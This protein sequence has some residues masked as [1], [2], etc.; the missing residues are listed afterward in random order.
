MDWVF[1][2]EKEMKMDLAILAKAF[3][4]TFNKNGI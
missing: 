3:G 4:N 1:D 2:G